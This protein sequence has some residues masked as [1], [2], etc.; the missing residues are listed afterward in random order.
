MRKFGILI[1]LT[2]ST[3]SLAEDNRLQR[4]YIVAVN[5]PDTS[6]LMTK[7]AVKSYEMY[8]KEE[9]HKAFAQSD[10]GSWAWVGSR[11]SPAYAKLNALA[12]CQSHNQEHEETSPCKVVNVDGEWLEDEAMPSTLK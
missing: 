5:D 8:L 4:N 1:L 10:T 6:R 9:R 12:K 3:S 2:L 11:T 7:K